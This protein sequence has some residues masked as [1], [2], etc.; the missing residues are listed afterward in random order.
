MVLNVHR[1]HKAYW[2]RG[3]GWKRLRVWGW[4]VGGGGE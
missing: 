2:G 4:G 1:H 3:E